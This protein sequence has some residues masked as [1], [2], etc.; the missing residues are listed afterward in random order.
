MSQEKVDKY[1]EQKAKRKELVEKERKKRR[2]GRLAAILI[3][4]VVIAGVGTGIGFTLASYTVRIAFE[5]LSSNAVPESFRGF[6]ITL[7]YIGLVSLALYGVIGHE[8]PF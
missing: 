8:L 3:L 1:K 7:I 2:L 5:H 4:V 6:P